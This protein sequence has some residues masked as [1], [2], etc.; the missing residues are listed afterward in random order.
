MNRSAI[1]FSVAALMLA[2]ACS[3]QQSTAP[4]APTDNAT[5]PA[6]APDN[7]APGGAPSSTAP[8]DNG[9]APGTTT[10][11]PDTN[12]TPNSGSTPR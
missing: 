10:T 4:S 3:R 1:L 11:T 2:S 9:P 6:A 7:T 12:S 8:S 5:P